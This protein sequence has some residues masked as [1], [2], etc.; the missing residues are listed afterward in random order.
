MKRISII[1][2][3]YNDAQK[4]ERTLLVLR[5]IRET[6]YSN[7]EI[8]VSV[9]ASTDHTLSVAHRLAD[10]VVPG[11]F[12]S[13]GR[14]A[15]VAV[16]TGDVFIFLDA[17]TRPY[18]GTLA[19]I[20]HVCEP[21][22]IGSCTAHAPTH[23]FMPQ[24]AALSINLLRWSH[25]LHGVSTLIF[26]HR[27]IVVDKGIQYNEQISL[28]EHHDFIRRARRAGALWTF[29]R[30][31]AG[32]TLSVDRYEAWG[33]FTSFVFWIHWGI[34]HLLRMDVADLQQLY[35]SKRYVPLKL[36]PQ[37]WL[38]WG[39]VITS[40]A[41]VVVGAGVVLSGYIGP[42]RVLL[43]IFA[44][45]LR[46]DP[47]APLIHALLR[48]TPQ[49]SPEAVIA[50]GLIIALCSTYLLLVHSQRLVKVRT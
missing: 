32:Y 6:E 42:Q 4:L 37:E 29:V 25:L 7:I 41:G 17:D 50:G 22:I 49:F 34:M 35:W 11:G 15:G 18:P 38:R 8:I 20:A 5:D 21:N 9:R 23:R 28:G 36:S 2:P 16:A 47:S 43:L 31:G 30:A 1:I 12:P 44:E 27:N 39:S 10:V 26:C 46:E 48:L 33:Y 13:E 3:A 19:A 14:N 24:L 40:A 45:E